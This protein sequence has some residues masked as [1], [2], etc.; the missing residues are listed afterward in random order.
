LPHAALIAARD[1]TPPVFDR[2]AWS[3]SS[4]WA[5]TIEQLNQ[6]GLSYGQLPP[7]YDVDDAESLARMV[8]SLRVSEN[9]DSALL[10]LR[11]HLSGE[12]DVE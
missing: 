7:W 4:V 8:E 12:H 10:K 2:I 3:T 1:T 11:D 6:A 9:L 5:D